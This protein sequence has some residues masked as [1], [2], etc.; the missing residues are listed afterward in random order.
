ML[1]LQS[2]ELYDHYKIAAKFYQEAGALHAFRDEQTNK[3][4]VFFAVMQLTEFNKQIFDQV[5]L[6]S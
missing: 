4:A 5:S 1:I 3:R 2:R 6:N